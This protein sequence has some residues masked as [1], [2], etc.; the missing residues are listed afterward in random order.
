MRKR[1]VCIWLTFLL[2]VLS[3]SVMAD[4]SVYFILDA[5]GSMWG[6][7]NGR[8]K[9]EIAKEVLMD[10]IPN[11]GKHSDR[12]GLI[13]YGHRRKGDCDDIEVLVEL[14]LVDEAKLRQTIEGIMPKGKTPI[15][16]AIRNA[17]EQLKVVEG[18]AR[19]VLISDGEETCN[20]DP[21]AAVERLKDLGIEFTVDVIGFDVTQK[22]EEQL[23]CIARAGGGQYLPASSARELDAA[24][25]KAESLPPPEK[26]PQNIEIVLDRSEAMS[27]PFAGRTKIKVA[28]EGIAKM[29]S[30]PGAQQENLALRIFG[31]AC[32]KAGN[33]E[34]E[35]AFAKNN[36]GKVSDAVGALTLSGQPTQAAALEAAISDF[37]DVRRFEGVSN[38][39]VVISGSR[40]YCD[41]RKAVSVYDRL[42][43]SGIKPNFWYIAMDIPP[44]QMQD[45]KR[46]AS[47]TGGR[48][49]P[50]RNQAEFDKAME[51]IFEIEPV[52][53]GISAVVKMLN[54]VVSHLNDAVRSVARED[55]EGA[56]GEIASGRTLLAESAEQ[57]RDLGARQTREVFTQLYQMAGDNRSLQREIFEIAETMI[58]ARQN[59]EIEH[60]NTLVRKVDAS[61]KRYNANVAQIDN[62][63]ISLQ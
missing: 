11:F 12:V 49:F 63:T 4:T 23:K 38:R 1:L 22:Q 35:V 3:G 20:P 31:G 54:G 44:D 25:I 32:E 14:G 28:T 47:A 10:R 7:L 33:T 9:I 27:L 50:V 29:V 39:V 30:G 41:P 45:V 8:P 61:I 56:R 6:Q 58:T 19:I 57:F 16:G 55:Y 53:S 15:A 13:V 17:T 18:Q 46:L 42:K 26:V 21:C 5:S 48:F 51:R 36:S 43:A 37:N 59:N 62:L 40:D 2:T 34:L 24:I 60:Y 52:I